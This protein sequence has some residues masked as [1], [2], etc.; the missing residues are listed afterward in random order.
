VADWVADGDAVP[1]QA[2][3]ATMARMAIPRMRI[4][5]GRIVTSLDLRA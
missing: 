1:L 2:D 5:F 3:S 4:R